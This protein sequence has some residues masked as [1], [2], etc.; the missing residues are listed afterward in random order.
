[1]LF[2]RPDRSYVEIGLVIV[3]SDDWSEE[4][5]VEKLRQRA[6]KAGA[7]AVVIRGLGVRQGETAT[8]SAFGGHNHGW[9]SGTAV[10]RAE[11]VRRMEG[12]AIRYSDTRR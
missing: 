2:E 9:A 7:D 3:E 11:D 5:M 10:T 8:T 6:R 4:K 1:V 12:L